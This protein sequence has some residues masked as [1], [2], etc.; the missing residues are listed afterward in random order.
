MAK[1]KST[2]SSACDPNTFS[3][4]I[5]YL[6][7]ENNTKNY[8]IETVLENQKSIQNTA[9]LR[10]L[11]INCNE[12]KS[13]NLF[14][15]PK[16]S[17]SNITPPS[18]NLITTS[19]S[20]DLLSENTENSLDTSN[21]ISIEDNNAESYPN[22]SNK[23]NN[24][25]VST[26]KKVN[27]RHNRKKQG[28]KKNQIVTAIAGDSMVKDIYGWELSDNNEK[29]VVKHFSGSTTED[30]MTYIKPNRFIIH[31]GINDLRSD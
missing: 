27:L 16:K 9:D 24:T 3:D 2:Y 6:R 29:V 12:L 23:P 22:K 17:L 19:N 10:T 31:V 8:I 25:S 1:E 18:S 11:D 20:F 5:K 13:L 26:G 14:I 28:H 21:V 30:M 15:L 4:K 7:E